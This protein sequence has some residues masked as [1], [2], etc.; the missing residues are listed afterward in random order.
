MHLQ[1]RRVQVEDFFQCAAKELKDHSYQKLSE[2]QEEEGALKE[3]KTKMFE[4]F[5]KKKYG[6]GDPYSPISRLH[7]NF[8][9]EAEQKLL[10]QVTTNSSIKP[11]KASKDAM[12]TE[13]GTVTLS[14]LYNE[15]LTAIE[16][17]QIRW[18]SLRAI[19]FPIIGA[20]HSALN[21]GINKDK[22]KR[23][24]NL[25]MTNSTLKAGEQYQSCLADVICF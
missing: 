20:Q 2:E 18:E 13:H 4:I 16:F 22:Q 23:C 19:C 3:R 5:I 15:K 11:R 7:T 21:Q 14:K 12:L 8:L 24:I 6:E 10:L 17:R 25:M 1:H 9:A